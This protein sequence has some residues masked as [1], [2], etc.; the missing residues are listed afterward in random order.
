MAD[1]RHVDKFWKC[2]NLPINGPTWT[3]LGWSSHHIPDMAVMMRLP[4][5]RPLLSNGALNIQ[6]L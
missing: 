5:Q 6:Q 4:W 2:Y 1:G 3:K